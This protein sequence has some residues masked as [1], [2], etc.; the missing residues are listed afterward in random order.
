MNDDN[1]DSNDD[2]SSD[3]NES[4]MSIEEDEKDEIK[5]MKQVWA[6]LSPPNKEENS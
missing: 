2:F 5:S 4:Y 3:D 6:Y 1:T